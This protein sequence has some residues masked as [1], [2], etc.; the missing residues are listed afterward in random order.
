MMHLIIDGYA[1]DQQV[2]QDEESL[3][4]L[5]DTYPSEI[6]MTK[7]SKP[8]VLR[9]KGPGN[10]DWGISGLVVI[11]ESHISVHT[12]VERGFVNIDVF[13]CKDFD[14]QRVLEDMKERFKLSK[15]RSY[16]LD[17]DWAAP[18]PVDASRIVEIGV[19]SK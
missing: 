5:L 2:L 15:A 3:R 16:L 6:G 13:S 11:A 8:Y 17:R 14:S 18:C 12:F 4:Q 1:S 7:I 9:Y 10:V 19:P